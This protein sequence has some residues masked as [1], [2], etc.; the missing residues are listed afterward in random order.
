MAWSP[1]KDRNRKPTNDPERRPEHRPKEKR[2]LSEPALRS[3]GR[4]AIKGK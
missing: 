3:L 4:R 2:Q 1:E